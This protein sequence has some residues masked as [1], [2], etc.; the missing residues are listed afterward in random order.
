MGIYIYRSIKGSNK[1]VKTHLSITCEMI[2]LLTHVFI[3]SGTQKY[4]NDMQTLHTFFYIVF[5]IKWL[6]KYKHTTC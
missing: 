5:V 3:D 4:V 1:Y 2:K 6:D